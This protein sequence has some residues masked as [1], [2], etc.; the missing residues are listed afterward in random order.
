STIANEVYLFGRTSMN[1]AEDAA[2]IIGLDLYTRIA[3][4]AGVG[5]LERSKSVDR[6][7]LGNYDSNGLPTMFGTTC[8]LEV[9]F[10]AVE[11]A[12]A[13][14]KLTA[15]K[16]LPTLAGDL[17]GEKRAL[18]AT[19][20]D[21]VK[22]WDRAL[23]PTDPPLFTERN[24]RTA[25]RD[26]L[27]ALEAR[28]TKQIDEAM[29]EIHEKAVAKEA[30]E[31]RRIHAAHL[32]PLAAQVQRLEMRKRI[33]NA[34]LARVQDQNVP[35][36]I[37]PDRQLQRSLMNAWSLFGK[38]EK[39]IAQVTDDFNRV[40]K[41][42]LRAEL[43]DTKKKLLVRLVEYV[44][45][46]L[47]HAKRHHGEVDSDQVVRDLKREALA[48]PAMR[49]QL[50]HTHAHKRH[51]FDL[52]GVSGMNTE[53]ASPPVKRL[54]EM[55]TSGKPHDAYAQDFIRW[56]HE[57]YVEEDTGLRS[58]TPEDLTD[59]LVQYLRDEVYLP[60]LWEMNLFDLLD[61]CCVEPG[62]RANQKTED[63]LL[64]H[65]QH[66]GGLAREM[67]AFEAQLWSEGSGML[68]TSLYLGMTWKSGAQRHILNRARGRLSAIAREGTSPMVASAVDP[69]RMQLVYG[70]HA[71]SLGTISDFY[72]DSNSF[73]SEF[74]AHQTAWA[75]G[76]GRPYGQSKAPV[77]SSGEM[78]RLVMDPSALGEQRNL[79]QRLIRRAQIGAGV[80]P[81][82]MHSSPGN[83]YGGNGY[84][85][86]D[87]AGTGQAANGYAAGGGYAGN[88]YAGNGAAQQ[89]GYGGGNGVNGGNGANPQAPR[90]PLSPF[91]GGQR[92]S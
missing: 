72:Q 49:G 70:Q 48:M 51:L 73:M 62:E 40:Q 5:F 17:E 86:N 57:H 21:E 80:E 1:S 28:L 34:A 58:V 65:L 63:I 64:A 3:N 84:T 31:K 76:N 14:A 61:A 7:T 16:V 2:R 20:L 60:R 59:R 68:S 6:R 4:A 66:I 38:K 27:D 32:G 11:T 83:G 24:F 54:Y 37:R 92:N 12:T 47:Q 81:A 50:D 78:E 19:E 8:P 30:E 85:G 79:P 41:R 13:F 43:L 53:N 69:H 55:L 88:G 91:G 87:Y 44:D 52:P 33:Y 23:A 74:L 15:S 29:R 26:R 35:S 89:P 9:M 82:W 39:L 45:A 56:M 75:G 71:I 90:G 46:E 25:G 18:T 77:F 36:K 42:N 10:P 67:V 22:E